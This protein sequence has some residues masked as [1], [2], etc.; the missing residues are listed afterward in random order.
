MIDAYTH[1][2]LTC[3]DPIADMK[4]RM[5]AA[6]IEGALA[7][8]TWKADNLS[9]LRQMMAEPSP[10]FRVALCFRP[11]LDQQFP[12]IL[13]NR[14]VIGL[15]VRTEDM[16]Q[17]HDVAAWLQTLGKWL[18][19]HAENGIGPLK[20]ELLALAQ[21]TPGLQI[22]LPH[23]GWPTQDKVEDPEWEAAVSELAEIPGMVVG[24]SA[25]AHFSAEPFPHADVEPFAARLIGM[26]GSA[27]VVAAGDYPL[28]DKDRYTQYLQLAQDWIRRADAQW[29]P[30]FERAFR[31][32]APSAG[33]PGARQA[34]E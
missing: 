32:A 30:R 19:P 14:S 16:A 21:R 1:L 4:A 34:V 25:I 6:G 17:L 26:F 22:Y 12:G 24:I 23:L 5:A 33:K 28:M 29:S 7:V 3:A 10:Q 27:S 20:K 2:D 11:V 9:W 15:R 31:S 18:I 13:E 8:E